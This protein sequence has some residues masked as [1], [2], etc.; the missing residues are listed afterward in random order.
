VTANGGTVSTTTMKAVDVFCKAIDS[1]GIRGRIWRLNLFA[2]SNLSAATVPLYRGTSAA[3][4]Q[5]GNTTDTNANFVS[6]D[7]S[8][9]GSTAGLKGNGSTKYLNTGLLVT[10]IPD[11]RH[12]AVHLTVASQSFST[13]WLGADN[14]PDSGY[15][16][17]AIGV[18]GDTSTSRQRAFSTDFNGT[19]GSNSNASFILG[20]A[21]ASGGAASLYRNS[22][23]I[24][25]ATTSSRTRTG[26]AHYVFAANRKNS[27]VD[28]NGSTLGAYSIGESMTQAQVSSFDSAMRTF[29]A[30]LGRNA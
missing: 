30:A 22:T 3:G 29:Q 6:G 19:L 14:Y 8:E 2:G 25:T 5:Y 17:N 11:A 9:T 13:V 23:Q 15:Y 7:Y 12:L 24:G 26:L 4:T 1:A 18:G 28:F 16:L 27:A 21:I 20:N 10:D